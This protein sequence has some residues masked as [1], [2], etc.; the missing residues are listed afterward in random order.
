MDNMRGFGWVLVI[1]GPLIAAAWV[2]STWAA[3]AT[4]DEKIMMRLRTP[5]PSERAETRAFIAERDRLSHWPGVL[6]GA[7]VSGVGILLL[8]IRRPGR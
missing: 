5:T 1:A 6:A 3:T 7:A 2:L 8:T 4:L